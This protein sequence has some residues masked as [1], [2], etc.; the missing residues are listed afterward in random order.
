MA[1]WT[2]TL[3]DKI[4]KSF[5][6]SEGGEVSIGRGAECDVTIDNTAISRRHVSLSLLNGVYFVSDLGSTNGTFVKGKK[7]TTD[8]MVSSDEEIEFGKFRLVQ[9]PDVVEAA[10]LACSVA[11]RDMDMEDATIFVNNSADKAQA[12]RQFRPKAKGPVLKV[13]KGNGTPPELSLAGT[14]SIKI[15]KDPSC[16]LI[17]T[18]WFVGAA[19]CY[20]IKRENDFCLVPQK[21]WAST[22]VNDAKVTSERTLRPGDIIKIRSTVIRFD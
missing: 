10:N 7:I 1:D 19:Q 2:I 4:I 13:I 22:L 9:A 20:L 16:D 15:G 6:I 3:H 17:I 11:S 12:R 21:S 8:E 14:N 5:S 18:G